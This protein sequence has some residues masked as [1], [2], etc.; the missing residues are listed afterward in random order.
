M[1]GFIPEN[2]GK[3]MPAVRISRGL[4]WCHPL[5]FILGILKNSG[6]GKRFVVPELPFEQQYPNHWLILSFKIKNG[7]A[8]MP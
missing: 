4:A 8:R 2:P 5:Y 7:K 6:G 3:C 1:L